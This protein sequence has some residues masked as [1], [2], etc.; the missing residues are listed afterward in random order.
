MDQ[1]IIATI[2][3]KLKE[4]Q[5]IEKKRNYIGASTIGHQCDRKIWLDYM[6]EEAEYP[7]KTLLNFEI[8]KSLEKMILGVLSECEDFEVEVGTE[9]NN[10]L[11]CSDKDIPEFKGHVDAILKTPFEKKII[12]EIKTTKD[13]GF[14][15]LMHKDLNKAGLKN[16]NMGYYTQLQSYMGMMNVPRAILIVINKD[17]SELYEEI[18]FFNA[19]FYEGIKAKA[20]QILE[21]QTIPEKI[22]KSPL[23]TICHNC[24]YKRKCH[25]EREN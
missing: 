23:F 20:R 4:K 10:Y 21:A 14:S 12:L 15:R 25:Y 5:F 24:K 17:N 2:H 9:S 13:S 6:G 16:W 22:N 7:P 18:I 3:E 1:S 19:M 11:E 8:G